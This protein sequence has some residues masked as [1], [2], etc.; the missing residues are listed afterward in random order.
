MISNRWLGLVENRWFRDGYV[1]GHFASGVPGRPLAA[2]EAD[3]KGLVLIENGV[4]DPQK[5]K[6][7]SARQG[8]H[9]ISEF[10]EYLQG[11]AVSRVALQIFP[12]TPR[13]LH[14]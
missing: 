12:A 13:V 11:R 2:R 6:E 9:Q 10:S 7:G 4:A 5:R 14:R 8:W 3:A 1:S